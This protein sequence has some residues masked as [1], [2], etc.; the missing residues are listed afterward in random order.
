VVGAFLVDG[1]IDRM[2]SVAVTGASTG[3]G[4]ATVAELVAGGFHVWA[5]VR[6]Q[7][8]AD[9]LTAEHGDRVTPLLVDL[10]DHESVRAAGSRVVAAGALHGLVNNAGVALAA[11]LEYLPIEVFER[12]LDINLVGQ[13]LMT[14]VMLPA[15]LTDGDAR[16]TFIGSVA[17]RI[18]PPILGAYATSKHG[19]VG[20][21]GSLRA[22]L[23]PYGVRVCLI[24][25][26]TIATP[27]WST[28]AAA[29]EQVLSAI[30]ADSP[31][32]AEQ[33]A[34]ARRSAANG[35]RG[36]DPRTVARVVLATMTRRNPRPRQTAGRDGRLIAVATRLL[37][38]RAVYRLTAGRA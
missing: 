28:S 26:G 29:A 3:I 12:Q 7:V 2:R 20:L 32:Y 22:E 5:T 1:Y 8:D 37:P 6:Q 11:P 18:S 33:M 27:I 23:A 14:Q 9:S 36:A 16:V 30:P 34:A 21:S 25:P 10:L 17:G 31:R 24:E 4:R 13:L 38:F 19:L 35:H 15:L